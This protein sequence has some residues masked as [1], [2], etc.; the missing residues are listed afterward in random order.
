MQTEIPSTNLQ[1]EMSTPQKS[2]L[3]GDMNSVQQ[4][5]LVKRLNQSLAE[6]PFVEIQPTPKPKSEAEQE[7]RDLEQFRAPLPSVYG[8]MFPH[9]KTKTM[10]HEIREAVA[11]MKDTQEDLPLTPP[12]KES[13]LETIREKEEDQECDCDE[14]NPCG[15]CR[16]QARQKRDKK[17]V[18]HGLD[19]IQVNNKKRIV[20][21]KKGLKELLCGGRIHREYN[22]DMCHTGFSEQF[23]IQLKEQLQTGLE[24][25]N[26]ITSQKEPE[27]FTAMFNVIE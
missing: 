1:V 9:L 24:I 2:P 4:Q 15:Y 6:N 12:K 17:R 16:V 11:T 25:V 18:D 23:L 5:L 14:E 3:W 10:L 19:A 27:F 13:N 8:E 22:P 21:M 26:E 7:K 20:E